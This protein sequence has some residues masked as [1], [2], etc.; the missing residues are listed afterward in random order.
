MVCTM[1]NNSSGIESSKMEQFFLI[2]KHEITIDEETSSWPF[3]KT[4]WPILSILIVYL[5]FVQIIGPKL[6]E[7]RNAFSLKYILMAYNL[8]QLLFNGYILFR[9]LKPQ[10]INKFI[11]Y[12]CSVNESEIYEKHNILSLANEIVWLYFINKV[13][14]LI[15]TVFF[16]LKKKQ[17]HVSFLHVYH[18]MN[19]AITSWAYLKMIK[20][21][22]AVFPL[23][24]NLIVHIVMYTYY[25]LASLGPQ[26][27]KYLWWKKHL[28]FFQIF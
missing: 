11:K 2:L 1:T 25:F 28:T 9:F 21:Y 14:D 12:G 6:M 10:V 19:M 8:S 15:D 13:L 22:H 3:M 23:A 24:L 4:P 26:I 16:V 27:Q 20:D 18:H 17:S 5:L 7:K